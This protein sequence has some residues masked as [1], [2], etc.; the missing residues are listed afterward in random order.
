MVET[1]SGTK[2]VSFLES[3]GIENA[4]EFYGKLDDTG[5]DE[6]E[7]MIGGDITTNEKHF[8]LA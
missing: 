4:E 7:R 5:L 2:V 6:I 1:S 8:F 3:K